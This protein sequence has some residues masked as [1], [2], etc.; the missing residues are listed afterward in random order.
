M[1]QFPGLVAGFEAHVQLVLNRR[2]STFGTVWVVDISAS[3]AQRHRVE[4]PVLAEWAS[5]G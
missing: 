1:R 4:N 2:I 3:S 5:L